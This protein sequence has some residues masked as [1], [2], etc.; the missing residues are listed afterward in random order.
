MREYNRTEDELSQ[1]YTDGEWEDNGF[2]RGYA[3]RG[4]RDV[5]ET[6]RQDVKQEMGEAL[7]INAQTHSDLMSKATEDADKIRDS[8]DSLLQRLIVVLSAG[9]ETSVYAAKNP[10]FDRGVNA[11]LEWAIGVLENEREELDERDQ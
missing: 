3:E 5:Y 10:D 4:L 1:I 9:L 11:G 2:G 8:Q 7:K 6:G